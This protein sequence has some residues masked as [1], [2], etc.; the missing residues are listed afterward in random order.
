MLFFLQQPCDL[1][2]A[3]FTW[4]HRLRGTIPENDKSDASLTPLRFFLSPTMEFLLRF[5]FSRRVS[6]MPTG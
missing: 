2:V 6:T 5:F 3:W 4:A 1:V